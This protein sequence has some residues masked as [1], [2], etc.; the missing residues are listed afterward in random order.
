MLNETPTVWQIVLKQ[1]TYDKMKRNHEGQVEGNC[2]W[3]SEI[4]CKRNET[5]NMFDCDVKF[6]D[7]TN[8]IAGHHKLQTSKNNIQKSMHKLQPE[9]KTH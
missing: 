1:F 4:C 2:E 7:E 5:K 8:D 3:Y 9:T 6:A